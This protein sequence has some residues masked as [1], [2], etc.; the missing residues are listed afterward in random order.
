MLSDAGYPVQ[1]A[2]QRPARGGGS[3]LLDGFGGADWFADTAAD[4]TAPGT[5]KEGFSFLLDPAFCC[6]VVQHTDPT[7]A[8]VPE[9]EGCLC[10]KPVQ[11]LPR[12][13]GGLKGMY[14]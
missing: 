7:G 13:W 10:Q 12:T 8:V 11:V 3:S 14:H 6:Y 1:N 9:V 4:G 2:R 5:I